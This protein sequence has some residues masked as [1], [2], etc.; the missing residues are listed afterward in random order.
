MARQVVLLSGRISSGKSTLSEMFV[1]RF[2]ATV[3]KT[4]EVLRRKQA[5]STQGRRALQQLGEDLDQKTGGRWVAEE[6]K[7]V[8]VESTSD[9]IIVDAIRIVAQAEAVRR[10]GLGRVVHVH[11]EAPEDI[12][13]ERYK[14]KQNGKPGELPNYAD[15]SKGSETEARVGDLAAAADVVIDTSLSRK[16]DVLTRAAGHLGLFGREYLRL[17]DVIV[18]AQYGSEG[19]GHISSYL[20]PEYDVLVRV[21]GPNAGHTVYEDPTPYTHHQL[22]SGT[23]RGKAQLLIGP[24]ATIRLDKLLKEIAE[25]GVDA[26]RLTIDPQTMIIESSDIEA[27]KGLFDRIGSTAQ[28]VGSAMSRRIIDRGKSTVRLARD[29]PEVLSFTA[30]TQEALERAYGQG[31]RIFLEGTQGTGL[32]LYHGSYPYVTSR[33]TTVAGCLAE[34]GISPSRVR[35][36]ILICRPYPIRVQNPPNGS[37]GPM[38]QEINWKTVTERSGMDLNVV[39]AAEKTSTTKRDRRVGEFDWALFRKSASLNAPTD[40][41]LT[42]SDYLSVENQKAYRF[43]QLTPTTIRFIE[44]M[45][46]V[47]AAP[48]SL[49]STGF[50]RRSIIDRRAW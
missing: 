11:L 31:K 32:S 38:A 10:S 29:V 44:E 25:C 34:A 7:R 3:L 39:T 20:A 23:R 46:R 15:L 27:E 47:A 17:V 22:P 9:F 19:K 37:S 50:D 13:A 26:S 45:E 40:I 49:I 1:R 42:F 8:L 33:D 12:L 16:E 43:E 30:D 41:A 18:G 2:G 6:L 4:N 48:V 35:H 36:I 28:G 24:G 21:G 5:D 14:A